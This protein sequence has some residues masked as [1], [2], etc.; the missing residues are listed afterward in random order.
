M[1]ELR[2]LQVAVKLAQED[3]QLIH[4]LA[5]SGDV[6]RSEVIR[7]E[8]GLNDAEAQLA[9]R[10]NK[11]YQD[12]RTELAKVEDDLAQNKEVRRQRVQQLD[13]TIF[14]AMVPGIVK[15]VR[16]TTKGGV[17]R[18]GEEFMQ[19]VP[20][21][22]KLLIEAKVKPSDIARIREGLNANI[23]FDAFDYTIFGAVKGSVK[24]VS[25]DT[26]KEDSKAGEISYY[27]VHIMTQSSPVKT[28]SGKALDIK[29]GMTA[30]VDIRT[31]ERTVL[32]Y[33]LKPIRKTL[34]ESF[35][36]R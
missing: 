23:R 32:N 12:A 17:L 7:V 24:Y 29:P 5:A 6:S 26:L 9:N 16:V 1:E 20:L 19:I 27:R 18:A 34:I 10:K 36:E 2:T 25:A 31:G 28:E 33:L 14:R 4:K 11:F 13:D 22:D 21:D 30:Q 15:N 35:G 3:A 8:R